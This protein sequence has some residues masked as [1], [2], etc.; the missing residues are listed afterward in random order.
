[1]N[2]KYIQ[3]VIGILVI[4]TLWSC[5]QGSEYSRLLKQEKAKVE[6]Q[7]SLFLGMYL[8]MTID[9][10]YKHCFMLNKDT[11]VWQGSKN[12][13]VQYYIDEGVKSKTVM[14]FYPSTESDVIEEMLAYF[15]YVAWA[16]WNK[17]LHQEALK[18]DLMQLFMEWYG[19]NEFVEVPH[20]IDSLCYL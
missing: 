14:N 7:D 16:P 4:A 3:F 18:Q 1:M 6:R 11:I 9:S 8:G 10:F 20:P 12:M 17:S 13:S 5:N 2:N 15:Q 19:G